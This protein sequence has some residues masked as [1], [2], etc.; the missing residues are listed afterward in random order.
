MQFEFAVDMTVLEMV[1]VV[2]AV[3]TIGGVCF[4]FGK[5]IAET[6]VGLGRRLADTMFE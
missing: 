3:S 6:M 4:G 1:A 2:I 5:R